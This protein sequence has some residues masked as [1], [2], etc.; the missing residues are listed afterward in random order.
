MWFALTEL[1]P[2]PIQEGGCTGV[3]VCERGG[4]GIIGG[5]Q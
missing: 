4:G 3:E 2:R 1:V 5:E